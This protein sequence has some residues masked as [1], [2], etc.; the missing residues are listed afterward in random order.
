MMCDENI[1]KEDN[2]QVDGNNNTET[3]LHSFRNG[4]ESL[5]FASDSLQ[6]DESSTGNGKKCNIGSSYTNMGQSSK[7]TSSLLYDA[8]SKVLKGYDWSLVTTAA[9]KT[10]TAKQRLHVKRPMNAFMVW[11]QAA[12]RELAGQYPHLHNAELSKSLGKLWRVLSEDEKKPFM[13]EAERLRMMH[14]TAHPDYK[15]QPRRR[16]NGKGNSNSSSNSNGNAGNSNSNHNTSSSTT[17]STSIASPSSS[18]SLS[19]A[20]I[21][22]LSSS[23][24]PNGLSTGLSIGCPSENWKSRRE[25][26][27]DERKSLFNDGFPRG[28]HRKEF[29]DHKSASRA[30]DSGRFMPTIWSNSDSLGP[31]SSLSTEHL[32]THNQINGRS[33]F[34]KSISD[35]SYLHTPQMISSASSTGP[36]SLVPNSARN[37]SSN[38]PPISPAMSLVSPSFHQLPTNSSSSSS[39]SKDHLSRSFLNSDCHTSNTNGIESN[40]IE[41]NS[42]QNFPTTQW[43]SLTGG[44]GHFEAYMHHIVNFC[45]QIQPGSASTNGTNCGNL[46]TSEP[47]PVSSGWTRYSDNHSFYPSTNQISGHHNV[48]TTPAVIGKESSSLHDYYQPCTPG[49]LNGVRRSSNGSNSFFDPNDGGYSGKVFSTGTPSSLSSVSSYPVLTHDPYECI[50]NSNPMS[51]QNDRTNPCNYVSNHLAHFLPPPR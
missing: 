2:F 49:D 38:S 23:T 15:Y 4:D 25:H 24:T 47:N 16:K 36:R 27:G 5:K 50:P 39:F 35:S 31:S 37:S 10:S 29:T 21:T 26:K 9:R 19:S 1:M 45:P 30:K 51:T 12:R 14:K 6:I 17:D 3:L 40:H 42:N 13:E 32:S 22:S 43:P 48:V 8:V 18:I 41:T 28:R 33:N 44:Y 46:S 11:A 20:S 7:S 34:A